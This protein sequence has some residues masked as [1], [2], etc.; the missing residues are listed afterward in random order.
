MDSED[1]TQD[2]P[3]LKKQLED[4]LKENINYYKL[5]SFKITAKF[6]VHTV[7]SL[8]ISFICLFV[9]LFLA[10]AAALALG[11]YWNNYVHGFLV[12]SGGLVLLLLFFL[13]LAKQIVD[14]PILRKLSELLNKDIKL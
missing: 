2:S 8:I 1:S 12:I 9:A 3:K 5:L 6:I 10:F 11:A 4:T 14:R 7:K 13:L